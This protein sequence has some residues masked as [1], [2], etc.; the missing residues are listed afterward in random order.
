[1]YVEKKGRKERGRDY[2][3]T[4]GEWRRETEWLWKKE[5]CLQKVSESIVFSLSNCKL[6]QLHW[7]HYTSQ[8]NTSYY[9]VIHSLSSPLHCDASKRIHQNTHKV[10]INLL[11]ILWTSLLLNY[12]FHYIYFFV[13]VLLLLFTVLVIYTLVIAFWMTYEG[14]CIYYFYYNT[15]FILT[16]RLL[17]I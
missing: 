16:C 3:Q 8:L 12:S 1:M 6:L 5:K 9:L 13:W 4:A 11:Q 17:Y 15:Y 2:T 14:R 10:R 7:L